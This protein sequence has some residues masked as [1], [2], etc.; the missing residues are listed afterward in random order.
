MEI[1]RLDFSLLLI[2]ISLKM[3]LKEKMH[4]KSGLKKIIVPCIEGIVDQVSLIFYLVFSLISCSLPLLQLLHVALHK[5][6]LIFKGDFFLFFFSVSELFVD[7]PTENDR[8]DVKLNITLPRMK[9]EREYFG[10][11]PNIF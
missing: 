4:F 5:I 2:C 6:L 9:C 11:S 10:L 3:I 1:C 8:L 7:N